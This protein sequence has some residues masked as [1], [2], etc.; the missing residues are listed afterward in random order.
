M[1]IFLYGENDFRSGEKLTEIKNKFL[2][3]NNSGSGQ[4]AVD[5]AFL[6]GLSVIDY[7]EENNK[8]L[9]D[10]ASSSGLFSSKQL[11][12]VKNLILSASSVVQE[13]S[14]EF[15]KSKKILISDK[16]IVIVFWE[17]G[18]PRKNN[19]LFKFLDKNSKSQKFEQL[20]GAK[21]TSW[22]SEQVE[23]NNPKVKISKEAVGKLV[24]YVGNN[25]FQLDNEI[26]KLTNF[27]EK[28]EINEKDIEVLVKSKIDANIFETIE[29]LS[30]GN[31]KLALKLLHGQLEKGEDPFYIL[32]MYTYQFR[33]LLKISEFSSQGVGN[34]YQIAKEA[35][36]HP[37][38]VQKGL[39]QLR[40]F[41][42]EKLKAVYKKL[43]KID[44]N[45]K[46]GKTDIKLALDK[47]VTEI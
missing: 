5:T 31:K 16:D 39:A 19:K 13:E 42:T 6:A 28:G 15:L 24:I 45:I 25:L 22:I 14:L 36:I 46:T 41:S 29:A 20:K 10:V 9:S 47:F 40:N 2:S 11:I 12:I 32:S 43:Q 33:N 34:Q 27:K 30:G 21:L 4:P 23:K 35:G 38:V 3:N 7:E 18:A 37:F 44:L 1:L 8:K 26:K 17:A